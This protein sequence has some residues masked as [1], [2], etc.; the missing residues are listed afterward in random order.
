MHRAVRKWVRAVTVVVGAAFAWSCGSPAAPEPLIGPSAEP[1][2]SCQ[3][4]VNEFTWPLELRNPVEVRDALVGECVDRGWSTDERR[5][6]G[7][8]SRTG[9][10]ACGISSSVVLVR[11]QARAGKEVGIDPCDG[12]I[13]DYLACIATALPVQSATDTEEALAETV[14]RWRDQLDAPGGRRRVRTECEKLD[15]PMRTEM[16]RYGCR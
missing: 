6:A 10:A 11:G 4:A 9:L 15:G 14:A 5:C 1:P 2:P 8:A 3:V 7:K 13:A 16:K 12:L